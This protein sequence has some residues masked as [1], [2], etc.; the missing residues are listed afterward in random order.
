MLPGCYLPFLFSAAAGYPYRRWLQAEHHR[1]ATDLS[2]ILFVFR[3][4]ARTAGTV[5]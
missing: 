3:C 5:R 1:A 2:F 4:I